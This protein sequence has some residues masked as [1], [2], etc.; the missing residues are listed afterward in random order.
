ML[1]LASICDLKKQRNRDT[2]SS[3]CHNFGSAES[4]FSRCSIV[5]RFWENVTRFSAC[6]AR[7]LDKLGRTLGRT[8][9]LCHDLAKCDTILTVEDCYISV[10]LQSLKESLKREKHGLQRR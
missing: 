4:M 2:I 10:S 7:F 1:Y 5:S 6:W 3:T 9:Q 8:H